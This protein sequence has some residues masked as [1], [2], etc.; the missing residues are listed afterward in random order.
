MLIVERGEGIVVDVNT[1]RGVGFRHESSVNERVF[2]PYRKRRAL[3][4]LN[5]T[6]ERCNLTGGFSLGSPL[7]VLV[8][9]ALLHPAQRTV[10]TVP[11]WKIIPPLRTLTLSIPLLTTGDRGRPFTAVW[12]STRW[13]RS[14]M[15]PARKRTRSHALNVNDAYVY[16]CVFSGYSNSVASGRAVDHL[17]ICNL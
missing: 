11:P 8:L 4:E 3:V 6:K 9:A 5:R 17:F 13:R 14:R 16:M 10:V 7:L 12:R 2:R 1:R 15:P